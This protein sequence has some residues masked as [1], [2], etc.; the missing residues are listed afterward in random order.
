MT[1]GE[2]KYSQRF[3]FA[4]ALIALTIISVRDIRK[5]AAKSEDVVGYVSGGNTFPMI[6]PYVVTQ[7]DNSHQI[8]FSFSKH[9]KYPLYA[10]KVIVGRPYRAASNTIQTFGVKREFDEINSNI[11]IPLR[12]ENFPAETVTYYEAD[13]WARN[14]MWQEVIEARKL[15]LTYVFRRVLCVSDPPGTTGYRQ[16]FDFADEEFPNEYRHERIFPLDVTR[17]PDVEQ[18]N[19]HEPPTLIYNGR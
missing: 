19:P 2:M 11:N 7:P 3:V 13:M 17:L 16:V 6:F 5:D 12:F 18:R 4:T 10:V 1:L 8:G 14:G 15:G 9:G